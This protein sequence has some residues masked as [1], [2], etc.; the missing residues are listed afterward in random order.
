MTALAVAFGASTAIFNTTYNGQA[1]VDAELTN[2]ADVTAFGTTGQSGGPAS[3][4][5]WRALPGVTA[6]E[7][8]Q[9]RY[10]YVGADLQDLFGIDPAHDRPAPPR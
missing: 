10:A 5:R 8:M 4:R 2:G 6:A 3:R 7:P 1:R 9:H